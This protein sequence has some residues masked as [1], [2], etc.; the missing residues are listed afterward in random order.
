MQDADADGA[1]SGGIRDLHQVQDGGDVFF[2]M[3]ATWLGVVIGVLDC[4][5]CVG[6][7]RPGFLFLTIHDPSSGQQ[8]EIITTIQLSMT[9]KSSRKDCARRTTS[10]L[11][12][13]FRSELGAGF[14]A[15][16]EETELQRRRDV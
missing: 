12:S 13:R 9:R 6:H 8:T 1:F 10:L 3:D 4:S 5:A 16:L 2:V 7:V 11:E 14:K 15:S